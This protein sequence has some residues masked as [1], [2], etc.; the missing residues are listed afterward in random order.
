[1]AKTRTAAQRSAAMS[2]IQSRLEMLGKPCNL[3]IRRGE[4]WV[5]HRGHIQ[6]G[7]F[8]PNDETLIKVPERFNCHCRSQFAMELFGAW[9]IKE[10]E[11]PSQ[12][13][14]PDGL[15]VQSFDLGPPET[16]LIICNE[17]GAPA[18]Q[19]KL[20]E[21]KTEADIVEEACEENARQ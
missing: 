1:M 8:V 13:G 20:S 2:A 19:G 16:I 7:G 12:D 15:A 10:S 6:D 17:Q 4:Q 21:W 3:M 5:Q 9:L 18:L 11:S 14:A